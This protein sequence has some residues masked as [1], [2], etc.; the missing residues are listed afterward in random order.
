MRTKPVTFFGFEHGTLKKYGVPGPGR[1]TLREGSRVTALLRRPGNWQT[2][3][4]W[5]DHTSDEVVVESAAYE[6]FSV[7]WC[8]VAGA[9]V[10]RAREQSPF[11]V[12]S[13]MTFLLLWGGWALHSASVLWRARRLLEAQRNPS[14]E[15][16]AR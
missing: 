12:A 4:G 5:Y 1:P 10:F 7:V 8:L 3:L 14:P 15:G 9:V 16:G 2:L 13:I 6:W 11:L